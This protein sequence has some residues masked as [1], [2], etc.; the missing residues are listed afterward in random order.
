MSS[1]LSR[2]AAIG[3]AALLC[4]T[5]IPFRVLGDEG[6]FLPDAL[7]QLPLDKL[8]KRGLKIPLTDIYNPN[9]LSIKDAVVIVDGGTGE[10]VSPEGLLLTNH[11]VA[12]DALVS[13][14]DPA[15]DYAANGYKANSDNPQVDRVP[16]EATIGWDTTLNGNLAEQLQEPTIMGAYEGAGITVLGKG[17]RVPTGGVGLESGFP[18]GTTLLGSANNDCNFAAGNGFASN[19][20]CN[21]SRI[22]G[23]TVTNSSQGGGGIFAHGWTHNLEVSNNRVRNNQGTLTGGITIGQGEHP[24]AYLA[25][26]G[27]PIAPG[28]CVSDA[29]LPANTQKPYCFNLYVNVHNNSV[30]VNSSEGDELFSS[31]PSG[32]GGVSFCTG[33][34]YYSFNNNWVCGNLSTGDGGGFAHLGYVWMNQNDPQH[35]NQG[36]RHNV[37]MFNESTNPT[38]PT[39]GG[40]LVLM[41]APDTD[42]TCP[43]IADADCATRFGGSSDGT[44]PGMVIDANL[45][46]GNSASSGAGGGLRIQGLNGTDVG[47][48]PT[49][50]ARWN[51]ALVTNNIIANNVAGWDGAGV[52]LQDSLNVNFVNNTVMS[53]DSTASSGV[54]FDAFFAPLAGSPGQTCNGSCDRAA[55]QPSG[56]SVAP[57]STEMLAQ[58]TGSTTCPTGHSAC[59]TVSD[60][61]ISNDVFWQNRA[62]HIGV[63]TG[64]SGQLQ[65]T[66]TLLNAITNT[67]ITSQTSIGACVSGTNAWDIG[68]RGDTGPGNHAS[69]ATLTPRFSILTNASENGNGTN[70]TTG[71]AANPNI[72][73]QYCNGSRIPPELQGLGFYGYQVPPGT[74]ES[75]VPVPVFNL[76]AGAT[77]DEGNNWININW[78]PLS[79]TDP[80][81]PAQVLGDYSLTASSTAAIDHATASGAPT[82][83]F[84]GNTRPAGSAPDIGAVEFGATSG[85]GGG[86]GNTPPALTVL[87]NFN[88]ANSGSLGANWNSTGIGITGNI[89]VSF[90]SGNAY[91]AGAGNPFGNSQG[92][93]FTFAGLLPPINNTGLVL[94]ATGGTLTAPANYV[95]VRYQSGGGGSVTIATVTGGA[96]TTVATLSGFGGLA[97][98]DTLTATVDATGAVRVWRTRAGTSILLTSSPVSTSFTGG[99]RIGM[100]LAPVSAVDNFSGGN[101]P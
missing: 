42:P 15:K 81:N 50:Q 4:L 1:R 17:V 91:W 83:D 101:V 16:F 21:P 41:G 22:D 14:S 9:G 85:G 2:L 97:N 3:L 30:T 35:P 8:K 64:A 27:A 24:D 13:A 48:F 40:G 31:T 61:L 70:N 86:G 12:F 29:G 56:L 43:G 63:T 99:G 100:Q 36:I 77:V 90:L 69:G 71:A 73:R 98:G 88:R 75:N 26:D 25:G 11:H 59:K 19:F 65:N 74:N 76:T 82:K 93:A 32:G 51:S 58:I 28:S 54:L 37:F 45:I 62:F 33:A 47:F 57:H 7:T 67:S 49:N 44:G 78:G 52:S 87:D 23:L 20:M 6:M 5:F 92:A 53:N 10:F 34:D 94:K 66:V 84:F 79:L 89:A 72:A 96:A 18:D 68:V 46:L 39:N 80:S 38:V 95:R 55:P 60:P